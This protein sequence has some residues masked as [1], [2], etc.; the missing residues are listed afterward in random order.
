M[1]QDWS[2]AESRFREAIT[3][4]EHSLTRP[5]MLLRP[6]MILEGNQWCALYGDFP[7]GV[8]GF[9]DTPDAAS[10]DFDKKWHHEKAGKHTGG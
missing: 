1:D 9:G 6:K 10:W 5:F 7:T 3:A 8:A 2:F 4:V